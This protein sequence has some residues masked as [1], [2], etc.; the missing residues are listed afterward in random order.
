MKEKSSR[1]NSLDL[2]TIS[3]A[4]LAYLFV[5]KLPNNG[6]S[7]DGSSAIGP[8]T[9]PGTILPPAIN[10]SDKTPK[11]KIFHILSIITG[12]QLFSSNSLAI[13]IGPFSVHA[14]VNSKLSFS[15]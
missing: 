1:R 11:H 13:L 15:S 14:I 2:C 7:L 6:H 9:L 8:I 4:I 3:R 12:C 5:K 10:V